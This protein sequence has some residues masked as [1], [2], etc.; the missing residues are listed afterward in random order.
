MDPCVEVAVEVFSLLGDATRVRIVAALGDGELSV[1]D[2]AERVGQPPTVVSQH[3]A[4]LRWGRIVQAR[5]QGSR[6]LYRLVDE[7]ALE[8]VTHAMQQAEH[9]VDADPPHHARAG[10]S[11]GAR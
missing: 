9:V 11:A 7:H 4:R 6:V 5:H 10:A 3:L 8:L 2:L 1:G